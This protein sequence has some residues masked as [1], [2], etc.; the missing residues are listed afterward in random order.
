LIFICLVK[1]KAKMT[2]ETLAQSSKLIEQMV[3]EGS[4]IISMYWTLG[5]Y[6]AVMITEGTDEKAT[7]KALLRWGDFLSTE[8]LVAVTREEAM[9][10]VE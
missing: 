6:D 8:T 9:K 1:W 5:R 10:L 2:K 4:K 3:R 7:M